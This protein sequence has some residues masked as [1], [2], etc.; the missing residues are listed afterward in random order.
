[1]PSRRQR[2]SSGSS[3]Y[4]LFPNPGTLPTKPPPSPGEQITICVEGLP[5]YKDSY[6]SLR[7]VRHPNYE[8][9]V[10]LREAATERMAGRAWYEGPV[11]LTM[12][13]CRRA[14]H[15]QEATSRSVNGRPLVDY[16]GGVF[17]SLDGSH[18]RT[19]TYLPIVYQDDS[20][21]VHAH[22]SIV[23][24]DEQG[25]SYTVTVEFLTPD[26]KDDR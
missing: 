13:I 11:A 18:G 23:N 12:V 14:F 7:N 25:D 1:M 22:M 3:N 17:D 15:P 24:G 10:K 4:E 6:R 20:Q 26:W 8:A 2:D 21:V 5:P 19:F 16:L 9:F